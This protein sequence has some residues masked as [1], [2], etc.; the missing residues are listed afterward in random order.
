MG[1]VSGGAAKAGDW[2]LETWVLVGSILTLPTKSAPDPPLNDAAGAYDRKRT[3]DSV[4]SKLF[5][6]PDFEYR[7]RMVGFMALTGMLLSTVFILGFIAFAIWAA[8]A[9]VT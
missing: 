3:G 1:H 9:I 7:Q 8:V 5:H 6:N 4:L 2:V